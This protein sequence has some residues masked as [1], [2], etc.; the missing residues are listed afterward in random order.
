[1]FRGGC[2]F[3]F[4]PAAIDYYSGTVPLLGLP[5]P[6]LASGT[7]ALC[8]G[9]GVAVGWVVS[10][11]SPPLFTKLVG[12]VGVSLSHIV[13]TYP[14]GYT[15]GCATVQLYHRSRARTCS[16]AAQLDAPN[17]STR[18]HVRPNSALL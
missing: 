7:V 10:F 1:M 4:L 16:T 9:C 8:C 14:L 18:T 17:Y 3:S 11:V 5:P 6:L 15:I 13:N 12:K 2:E